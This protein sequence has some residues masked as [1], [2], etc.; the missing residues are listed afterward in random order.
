[1]S[2]YGSAEQ[3]VSLCPQIPTR[4]QSYLCW[5]LC[6]GIRG[7]SLG[8]VPGSN[9]TFLI[10]SPRGRASGSEGQ[11]G[12]RSPG[13]TSVCGEHM[14]KRVGSITAREWETQRLGKST[15]FEVIL[16][17]STWM[18][19]SRLIGSSPWFPRHVGFIGVLSEENKNHCVLLL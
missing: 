10:T 17:R 19:S 11:R 1:M 5:R 4:P 18:V 2:P 9:A 8:T 3:D 6:Q 7:S 14:S 15:H 12:C 16:S 13:S